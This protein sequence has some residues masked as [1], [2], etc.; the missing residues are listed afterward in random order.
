MSVNQNFVQWS[1]PFLY[2]NGSSPAV[3]INDNGLCLEMHNGPSGNDGMFYRLGQYSSQ[4]TSVANSP[5]SWTPVQYLGE[6]DR[7]PITCGLSN[8]FASMVYQDDDKN[9]FFQW[10]PLPANGDGVL[11]WQGSTNYTSG[12]QPAMAMNGN[13]RV[14]AVHQDSKVGNYTMW[15]ATGTAG[16]GI[17]GAAEVMQATEGSL[18]CN[19]IKV[20]INKNG[21]NN[22]DATI[23]VMSSV[24]NDVSLLVGIMQPNGSI[25]WGDKIPLEGWRG[26]FDVALDDDNN[27]LIASTIKSLGG[28]TSCLSWQTAKVVDKTVQFTS[29]VMPLYYFN[30]A[31]TSVTIN[32]N[33]NIILEICNEDGS[34]TQFQYFI[35]QAYFSQDFSAWM[36]QNN[37]TIGDIPL[38]LLAIPGSHDSGT[39]TINILSK[40]TPDNPTS[41]LS[42]FAPNVG[43]AW[44]RSQG[45]DF[46]GQLNAGIRYFDI[47][48]LYLHQENTYITCHGFEGA[49]ISDL[50]NDINTFYAQGEAY[51]KE[52]IL[53]DMNHIFT[54]ID[55][56]KWGS[57]DCW[58]P[59]GPNSQ[60]TDFCNWINNNIG[61]QLLPP[62]L[63]GAS[64]N[65]IYNSQEYKNGGRIILFFDDALSVKDNSFYWPNEDNNVDNYWLAVD[66][67]DKVEDIPRPTPPPAICSIWPNVTT[68]NDLVIANGNTLSNT[69]QNNWNSWV[70]HNTPSAEFTVLQCIGTEDITIIAAGTIVEA[71]TP[72]SL[73]VWEAGVCTPYMFIL[74]ND[75][76]SIFANIILVDW[77]E[78]T[79]ITP[80]CMDINKK[81]ATVLAKAGKLNSAEAMA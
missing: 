75:N 13:S 8:S 47:R 48:A 4:I 24:I 11:N 33:G 76:R 2:D 65:D 60:F 81:K 27:L 39:Y 26:C 46:L 37:D 21:P 20:A 45:L 14:V 61:H 59:G 69:L 70:D 17:G 19:T 43:T 74:A 57:V 51:Q 67:I 10:A 35:G 68:L 23:V 50:F 32:N 9:L 6:G 28:E 80:M 40:L 73:Q 41:L 12:E 72:N 78:Q 16:E 42:H 30:I 64:L 79:M 31:D 29:E 49:G 36:G 1:Q 58:M 38:N 15:Y 5:M 3:A 25:V 77:L 66:K 44:S 34:P 18:Y 55:G 22:T 71:Y 62:S 52:I 53:L 56:I 63:N 54:D 7:N